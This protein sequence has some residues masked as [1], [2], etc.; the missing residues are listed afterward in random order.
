MTESKLM[1]GSEMRA[2][3]LDGETLTTAALL[4]CSRPSVAIK[5]SSSAI[6]RI[7]KGREIVDQVLR[8]GEVVYGVNTGFGLFSNVSISSVRCEH[9][10]HL[11]D[12]PRYAKLIRMHV[13]SDVPAG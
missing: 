9:P 3:C 8:S 11:A 1:L 13:T 6:E 12:G 4:R 5:L 2:V 10:N 7:S